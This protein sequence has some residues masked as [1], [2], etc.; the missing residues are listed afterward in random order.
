M[1]VSP[2]HRDLQTDYKLLKQCCLFETEHQ[3]QIY[4]LLIVLL[5]ILFILF[6]YYVYTLLTIIF[7]VTLASPKLLRLGIK[8]MQAF[9][10]LLS[11]FRNFAVNN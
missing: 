6:D 2:L 9:F 8:K 11:T 4:R 3:Q 10:V 1:R 7:F 5:A